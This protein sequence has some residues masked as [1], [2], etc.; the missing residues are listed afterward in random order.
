MVKDMI[1]V[2]RVFLRVFL[3]LALIM[4]YELQVMSYELFAQDKIVAIVN[5]DVITQK[6]FNDFLSFMRVQLS[7]EYKGRRLE[8]KIESMK[9]D[10]MDRLIEDRL[11]LQEAK[12]G[13]LAIDK[14]RIKAKVDEIKKRYGSDSEFQDALSKQ[15]MV[16]ADIEARITEQLLMHAIVERKIRGTIAINPTEVT[17]FYEKNNQEFKVPEQREFESVNTSDR[18][19]AYEVYKAMKDSPDL[20]GVSEKYP[21]TAN[22]LTVKQGGELRKDIE[23][24]VFK[25]DVGQV[26]EPVK[27]QNG[28]YIFRLYNIIPPRQETL[29]GVQDKIYTF[30]FDRKMQEKMVKWLDELKKNAYI[31]IVRG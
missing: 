12:K 31:K 14:N 20:T 3:F 30:L 24:I 16:Q 26:K 18:G 8:E 22:R 6:D 13:N 7:A 23:E 11:I 27:I 9:T 5:N 1:A 25:M 28:Y 19:L 10:L 2:K 15:G 21:V 29:S 4:S 17:D